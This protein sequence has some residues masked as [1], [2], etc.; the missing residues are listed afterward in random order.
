M[1]LTFNM[2]LT[3]ANIDSGD[4]RLLRHAKRQGAPGISPYLAWRERSPAF[5]EYQSTQPARYRGI[6]DVPYWAAFVATPDRHT[7]FVGLYRVRLAEQLVP[8]FQCPLTDRS[9]PAD[10]ID[11]YA[12][13]PVDDFTHYGGKLLVD[14]GPGT[15]SWVQYAD[16]RDKPILELR[17]SEADPPYPGHSG[18]LCQLS[19]VEALPLGWRSILANARGIYLLSCPRTREQYVGAAFAEGGF[20]ARWSQHA[21]QQG[22]AIAFRSRN[23]ED[24]RVSILEVAGSL[25]T[26]DDIVRMEIRW[27]E[28]LQSREMGLNRN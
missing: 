21:M 10:S 19:Q 2:M 13:E 9:I 3:R 20:L 4:V 12:T 14:W 23:P 26:D 17:R 5:E 8:A 7:L 18:F 6:F 24:Y 15:R 28:K 11:R 1:L 16:R 27:K 22:D 25:A